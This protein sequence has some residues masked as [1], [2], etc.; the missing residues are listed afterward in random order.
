MAEMSA[1]TNDAGQE[2]AEEDEGHNHRNTTPGP[3]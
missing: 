1:Q 3:I 2:A